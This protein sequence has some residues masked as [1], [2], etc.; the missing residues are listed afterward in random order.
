MLPTEAGSHLI[1]GVGAMSAT[2]KACSPAT[3]WFSSCSLS[4]LGGAT[5][6]AMSAKLRLLWERERVEEVLVRKGKHNIDRY[7]VL[8]TVF[9]FPIYTYYYYFKYCTQINK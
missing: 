3:A 6:S 5:C 9:H 2:G 7:I 1:R 4:P 8:L